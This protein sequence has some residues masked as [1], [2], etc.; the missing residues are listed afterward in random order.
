[1][2]LLICKVQFV[3]HMVMMAMMVLFQIYPVS[4]ATIL[5]VV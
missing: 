5:S 3:G 2:V 4:I 1:M